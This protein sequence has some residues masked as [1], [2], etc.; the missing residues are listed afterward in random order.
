MIRVG[1]GQDSHRFEEGKPLILAGK[2]IA[3]HIGFS[4][5]SDGDVI[6]HSIC[7]AIG[8]AIGKGSISTYAD[9]MCLENKITDSSEY[10]KH[11][12][13]SAKEKGFS[14]NNISISIECKTPKIEPIVT[15]LKKNI[16]QL[17]EISE[18][19]VGITATTGEKLTSFGKGEGVQVFSIVSLVKGE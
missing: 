3:N 6:Y 4:A 8:S 16:S 11:I 9:K 18:E 5:N 19:Q 15:D 10:V 7:N 12:L 1:I 13:N 17:L 2:T 14:V